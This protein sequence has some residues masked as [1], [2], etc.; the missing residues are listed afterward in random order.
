MAA[1]MRPH[2]RARFV[3]QLRQ[4]RPS[5][6]RAPHLQFPE[7]ALGPRA[8]EPS[9]STGRHNILLNSVRATV[10]P[11]RCPLRRHISR[12]LRAKLSDSCAAEPPKPV[13]ASTSARDVGEATP[14]FS[15]QVLPYLSDFRPAGLEHKVQLP[16]LVRLFAPVICMEAFHDTSCMPIHKSPRGI[17]G[18]A[19]ARWYS[20]RL[21]PGT[22]HPRTRT[23]TPAAQP[24]APRP[25]GH[26]GSRSR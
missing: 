6:P 14:C 2:A 20:S 21:E 13:N 26:R 5:S 10:P 23:G 19:T 17:T 15:S 25:S 22:K 18:F 3:G 9:L 4:P 16:F 24:G 8:P 1:W 7:H 12:G 11:N